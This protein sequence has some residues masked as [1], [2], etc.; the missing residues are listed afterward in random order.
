MLA[1]IMRRTRKSVSVAAAL[2]LAA[3]SSI[4]SAQADGARLSLVTILPG[5]DLY[6]AFGHTAI[7]VIDRKGDRMYNFGLSAHDFD[8]KFGLNMLRGNMEFMVAALRTESCLD[9]YRDV[10]RRGIVEQVLNLDAAR[11]GSLIKELDE[12]CSGK[13]RLYNYRYFADNCVTRPAAMLRELV[14]DDSPP[15]ALSPGKTL[16][17]SV[18]L[19]LEKRAW[20]RFAT[21]VLCGPLT[22]RPMPDGPIFLPADLM[23]WAAGAGVPAD[24]TM[25][26]LA[27][28]ARAIFEAKPYEDPPQAIPPLAF[29]VALLAAAV[30]FTALPALRRLPARVFDL[31]LFIAT[32]IP[33]IAILM[34]WFPAKYEEASWNLNLLWSSALPILA[35]ALDRRGAGTAASK[36]LFRIAAALALVAVV[37]G[38]LG[39]QRIGFEERL[40]AAA[41][42]LRCAARGRLRLP[43]AK[44][45]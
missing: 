43:R 14:G 7:R 16:R 44:A 28:P 4:V 11:A 27:G 21:D 26:A 8:I 23:D 22:D 41:V 12:A 40:I 5:K 29:I 37:G 9:F 35:V 20:L 3:G 33:A 6:S 1:P 42:A 13:N 18:A 34:F 32:L 25:V 31:V 39:M 19:A 15:F 45:A 2:V 17:S 38:G 10:E 36:W 30:L 24:G